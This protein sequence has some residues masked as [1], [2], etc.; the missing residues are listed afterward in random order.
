EAAYANAVRAAAFL[1]ER[2]AEI[3]PRES[4]HG[5]APIGWASHGDRREM[6]DFLSR[7]TTDVWTLCFNGYIDRLADVIREDQSRAKGFDDEGNTLLWWLPDDDEKAM[8]AVELLIA[9]GVDPAHTNKNG[10]TAADWARR[11]GMT[12]VA[13]RLDAAANV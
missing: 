11:R 4:T 10:N 8:R 9:A 7:Y 2:G 13:A 12:D 3:D 6:M 1:V 5:G